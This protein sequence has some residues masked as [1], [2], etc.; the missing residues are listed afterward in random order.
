VNMNSKN[1]IL[2]V[3]PDFDVS[4]ADNCDLLIK[5]TADN[6]SY[7][8]ID[9][10]ENRLVVLYDQQECK[11]VAAALN[12]V[13]S[14]DQHLAIPFKT[15][16]ASVY[17]QNSIAIPNEFFDAENL[18]TYAKFFSKEQ[19]EQLHLQNLAGQDFTTIFNLDDTMEALLKSTFGISKIYD[20]M[21]PLLVLSSILP[22]KHLILDFTVGTFTA[23]LTEAGKLIFENCYETEDAEE[24]KYYLL[25]MIQQ[26][27][28]DTK[29]TKISVSGIIH[30]GDKKFDALN[31]YFSEIVFN[32]TNANKLD[33][34]ILDNM[35]S[36]Y[37]S[38][39]LAL[40]LCE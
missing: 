2:L 39:L 18:N 34:R 33:N 13:L 5:I 30:E 22:E 20:H 40:Q 16:K 19:S 1:S 31:H 35:P 25:L 10:S 26:L 15:V 28:I 17:T 29:E 4:S 6:F 3:D 9:G 8:I 14:D 23:V 37:Y 24:F 7:A 27:E 32:T 12:D 36:Q 11:N 21:A 38:S